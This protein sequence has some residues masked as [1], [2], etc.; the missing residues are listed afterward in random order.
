MER[1][2]FQNRKRESWLE[3]RM[4]IGNR[5]AASLYEQMPDRKPPDVV[6]ESQLSLLSA[7]EHG[8]GL[9]NTLP[10]RTVVLVD[11][12]MP[13]EHHNLLQNF[14]DD[15]NLMERMRADGRSDI[16]PEV[17]KEA[18]DSLYM[19]YAA[20]NLSTPQIDRRLPAS[21][22]NT[23]RERWVR[24]APLLAEDERRRREE[25]RRRRGEEA[26]PPQN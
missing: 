19:N 12:R 8:P 16:H 22:N 20:G 26:I 24:M 25:E 17:V 23:T 2:T 18:H 6:F 5:T 7:Y 14:T 21:M 11:P 3:V 13:R 4:K 1:V 10:N 15:R 9:N